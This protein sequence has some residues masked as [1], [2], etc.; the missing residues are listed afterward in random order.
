M[1]SLIDNM[2]LIL[3]YTDIVTKFTKLMSF[4]KG[5]INWLHQRLL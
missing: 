3:D 2:K 4:L 1:L 5:I